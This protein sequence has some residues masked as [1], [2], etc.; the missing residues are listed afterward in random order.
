MP[1]GAS[2][3]LRRPTNTVTLDNKNVSSDGKMLKQFSKSGSGHS[4]QA[5]VLENPSYE[6]ADA[7]PHDLYGR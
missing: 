1:T 5:L 3:P 7:P 6:G 2:M 4:Y